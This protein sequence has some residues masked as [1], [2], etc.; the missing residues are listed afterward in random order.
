MSEQRGALPWCSRGTPRERQVDRGL[1]PGDDEFMFRCPLLDGPLAPGS[2][3]LCVT[4]DE[5]VS[6]VPS[7]DNVTCPLKWAALDPHFLR[8]GEGPEDQR[9]DSQAVPEPSLRELCFSDPLPH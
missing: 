9:G 2:L 7:V 1:L 5:E 8:A 3:G 6:L 4:Q